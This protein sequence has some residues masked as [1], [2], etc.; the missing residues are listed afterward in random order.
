[1]TMM[2][3]YSRPSSTTRYSGEIAFASFRICQARSTQ[4]RV[5]TSQQGMVGIRIRRLQPAGVFV[6]DHIDAK[7]KTKQDNVGGNDIDEA[8]G[9]IG[10]QCILIDTAGN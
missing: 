2:L 7:Q 8:D 3:V 5:L 10:Q 1:M 9:P 6:G 4:S